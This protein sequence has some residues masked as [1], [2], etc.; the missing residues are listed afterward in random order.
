LLEQVIVNLAINSRDAMPNGGRLKLSTSNVMLPEIH[1]GELTGRTLPYIALKVSDNGVG[2][3]AEIR[4]QIFEPFF[5]TKAPTKGTG[6]GLPTVYGIVREGNGRLEVDTEPGQGT[7]FSV[8][9][10]L[11]AS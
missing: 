6:L 9:L 11:S 7:T 1:E 5:T 10:P 2:M 4:A 3:S 8:F